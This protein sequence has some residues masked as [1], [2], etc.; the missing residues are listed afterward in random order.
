LAQAGYAVLAFDQS[1]FGSRQVEAADFYNRYPRWSQMGH[2][3]EDTRAAI[4]ALSKDAQVDASR[5]Y[6][7]GYSM[8]ANVALHTAVLDARVKGVVSLNGFT[9]LRTDTE[10]KGTGGIARYF[11]EHDLLPRMGAFAGKEAQLPYDYDELIAALAPRPVYV[12]SPQFDR[13]ATPAD[14]KLAVEQAKK[15]Y[16]LYKA[17]DKVLLDEPWDYNRLPLATQDRVIKWM[18]E[19]MK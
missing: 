1:G 6:L 11:R 19:K 17:A 14:V 5:V 7:F 13:D 4:D 3:V 15:V 10:D 9:P 8:G 12:L 16:G 2:M 18:G